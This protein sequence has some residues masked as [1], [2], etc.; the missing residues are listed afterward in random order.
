MNAPWPLPAPDDLRLLAE[1]RRAGSMVAASRTLAI[2]ASTVTR[3]MAAL[4][5]RLGLRLVERRGGGPA[6]SAAGSELA[7][8]A[9]RHASQVDRL[10]RRLTPSGGFTGVIRV[11]A[12]DGFAGHVLEV[13]RRFRARSPDVGFELIFENRPANLERT[14]ADVAIRTVHLAEPGLVYRSLPP[15]AYGVYAAPSLIERLGRPRATHDLE[16]FESIALLPPLDQVPAERWL[17]ER[18]RSS[19]RVSSFGPLL[20]AARAGLG[21]AVLPH[22]VSAGLVRL[23]PR[24]A[25]PSV[26][27]WL[28]LHPELRRD[29]HVRAFVE[30]LQSS[31]RAGW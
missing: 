31:F 7:D 22:A 11:T 5:R 23:L 19:I 13:I 30:A 18:T 20:E 4:E 25:V 29:P 24:A 3:R 12:G 15:L 1:V 28:A 9:E 27:L 10:L 26:P 17:I 6:L 16:T 8:A 2:A 14:E 21:V